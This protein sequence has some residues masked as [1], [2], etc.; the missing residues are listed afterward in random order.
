M[1]GL[2]AYEMA[3]QLL[4]QKDIVS[5]LILFDSYSFSR[6]NKATKKYSTRL[7]RNFLEKLCYY[8]ENPNTSLDYL[9]D[10]LPDETWSDAII[11]ENELRK[12]STVIPPYRELAKILGINSSELNLLLLNIT[13]G[14]SHRPLISIWNSFEVKNEKERE[15]EINHAIRRLDI[16]LNNLRA[17]DKYNPKPYPGRLT[18]IRADDHLSMLEIDKS[19]GWGTLAKGGVE[20]HI[21][22]GDHYTMFSRPNVK[23]LAEKLNSCLRNADRIGI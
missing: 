21:V 3:Q 9:I 7:L 10:D 5:Q 6:S 19:L 8:F 22:P 18:L 4:A 14:S 12:D 16:Y 20:V 23:L 15:I 1:G 11:D 17:M 2:I 13:N